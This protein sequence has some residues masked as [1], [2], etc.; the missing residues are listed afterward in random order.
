MIAQYEAPDRDILL[1]A[2]RQYGLTQNHKHLK[3]MKAICGLKNAPI[4]CPI[5]SDFY[6]GMEVTVP[7][8]ANS[9]LKGS[10]EEIKNLYKSIDTFLSE[11]GISIWKNF[12]S[13]NR[14]E[15]KI[16]IK[17]ARM[18]IVIANEFLK[19]I[20]PRTLQKNNETGMPIN[21]SSNIQ[22]P[23]FWNL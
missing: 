15:R 4:F 5:V 22:H 18:R 23:T 20:S 16:A 17:P 2:P 9:L 21:E 11:S 19:S 13:F 12:E 10:A 14:D 8:F 1:D 6:S 7:L 3:E